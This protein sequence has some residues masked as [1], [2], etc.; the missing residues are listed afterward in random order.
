M[1]IFPSPVTR[2][3]ATCKIS[4][5]PEI[6]C[7]N[8]CAEKND[9]GKNKNLNGRSHI[10][11]EI[12]IYAKSLQPLSLRKPAGFDVTLVRQWRQASIEG[13]VSYVH[14]FKV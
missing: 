11:F 12:K 13:T 2:Q 8:R 7:C 3:E 6:T 14:Y 9:T 10:P 1:C 4:R 5:K